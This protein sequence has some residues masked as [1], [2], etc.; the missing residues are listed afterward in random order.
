MLTCRQ[1]VTTAFKTDN[2]YSGSAHGLQLLLNIEQYEQMIGQNEAAGVKVI[3]HDQSQPPLPG[4]HGFMVGPGKHT[5]V[6]IERLEVSIYYQFLDCL[7]ANI[8]VI[9]I[10]EILVLKY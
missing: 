8:K 4:A 9:D 10:F 5:F 7:R 1:N 6:A 2:V 3:I